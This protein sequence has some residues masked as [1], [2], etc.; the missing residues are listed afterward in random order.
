MFILLLETDMP[1]K[2]SECAIHCNSYY[3]LCLL[4]VFG[5]LSILWGE[6]E[7]SSTLFL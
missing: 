4:S 5:G 6:K 3:G 2:V 1:V 7:L